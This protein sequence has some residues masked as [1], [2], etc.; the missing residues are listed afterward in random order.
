M[1]LW[2]PE[3]RHKPKEGDTLKN[4]RGVFR[5]VTNENSC[6]VGGSGIK[7]DHDHPKESCKVDCGVHQ[8]VLLTEIN[9]ITHR[10]TK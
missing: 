8:F 5:I 4:E 10:L 7:C 3:L 2:S 1:P 6:Y 9:Y